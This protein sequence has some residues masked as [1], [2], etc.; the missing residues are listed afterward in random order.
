MELESV[1]ACARIRF[2]QSLNFNLSCS[3]ASFSWKIMAQDGYIW[4]ERKRNLNIS[5]ILK[6]RVQSPE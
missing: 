3:T 5:Q 4:V 6:P 2:L 1:S